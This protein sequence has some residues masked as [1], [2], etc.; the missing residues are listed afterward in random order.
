MIIFY[1]SLLN[2][3]DGDHNSYLSVSLYTY[4]LFVLLPIDNEFNSSFINYLF[5]IIKNA[6]KGYK[7]PLSIDHNNFEYRIVRKKIQ[8]QNRNKKKI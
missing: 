3:G 5:R 2:L 7:I 6:K 1:F 4:H 8:K